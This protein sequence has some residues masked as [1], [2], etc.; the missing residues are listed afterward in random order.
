MQQVLALI[1]NKK[2]D[3][4]KLP[5]FYFMKNKS[6]HPRDRLSF[7]PIIIPLAM[8]FGELCN[9]V[10]REEPTTNK[11]Q[12]L[13]NQHTYEEHFHWQWLLEDIEKLELHHCSKLT[14]AMLFSFGE[15]TLKSRMVCYQ[16][17]HHTFQADPIF[18]FVAMQVAEVTANVF[19]NISQPVALEL[20]EITGQ[21]YRYFGMR[22]LHE[23]E[24]HHMNTPTIVS[25][26]QQ[27]ELS[28]EQRQQA[29]TIV[30][31]T[32]EAYTEAMNSC[33]DFVYK[34]NP[35]WNTKIFAESV[36]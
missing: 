15:A 35:T 14:D 25:F 18:K 19:F 36:N 21:D 31:L 8:G 30:E 34:Q 28:D 2:Q 22:H 13:L 12:A 16:I 11:I 10:F 32:F 20:Q 23:E 33:M 17:Y 9:H 24:H 4:A 6:I 29:I 26:F 27:L 7:A 3:F 5:L 1:E